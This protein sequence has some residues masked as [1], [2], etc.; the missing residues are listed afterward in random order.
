[1]SHPW[2]KLSS[3]HQRR[4]PQAWE[5]S[6]GNADVHPPQS[7]DEPQPRVDDEPGL[8]E[9]KGGRS[10][11]AYGGSQWSAGAGVQPGRQIDGEYG[12][13][14]ELVHGLDDFP[15]EAANL[16]AESRPEDG[17][18]D[19]TALPDPRP[20]VGEIRRLVPDMDGNLEF[21]QDV[22]VAERVALQLFRG[23]QAHDSDG[24]SPAVKDS[25]QH[26][27]VAR[28]VPRPRDDGDPPFQQVGHDLLVERGSPASRVLHEDDAG[29][30]DLLDGPAVEPGHLPG[31]HQ[32]VVISSRQCLSSRR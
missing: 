30:A 2:R 15:V 10:R 25:R 1:M 4:I 32:Q 26:E 13:S 23:T 21:R 11:G 24:G 17:V 28:I 12:N 20:L 31:R 6:G 19:G 14:L 8:D 5:T 16:T 29:Y 22:E 7:S 18:D 27:A 3:I 9:S